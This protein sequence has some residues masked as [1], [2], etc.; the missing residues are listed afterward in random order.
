VKGLCGNIAATVEDWYYTVHIYI[1]I[2]IG[3]GLAGVQSEH[4]YRVAS[5]SAIK[6]K[7]EVNDLD[8]FGYSALR[9]ALCGRTGL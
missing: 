4:Y 7:D 3:G 8:D 1:Y 2:Y 9:A 6:K 5:E